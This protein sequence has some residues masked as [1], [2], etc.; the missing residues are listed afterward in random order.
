MYN[1]NLAVLD[2]E[3][4]GEEGLSISKPVKPAVADSSSI[5]SDEEGNIDAGIFWL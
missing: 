5:G 3:S 4:E 1:F 2:S